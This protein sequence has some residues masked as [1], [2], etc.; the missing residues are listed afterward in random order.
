MNSF[1]IL[2][3]YPR[4]T[5]SE[6]PWG[7]QNNFD[8]PP[9]PFLIRFRPLSNRG[10]VSENPWGEQKFLGPPLPPS[11][12]SHR[13]SATLK[14]IFK[15]FRYFWIFSCFLVI[16][17]PFF[18]F[19]GGARGPS[20]PWGRGGQDGLGGLTPS[21][22]PIGA[23]AFKSILLVIRLKNLAFWQFLVIFPFL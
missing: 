13:I 4:R 19:L 9:Q 7:G 17:Y 15:I 10:A 8:P 20:V 3:T 14:S 21:T 22:G 23:H 16:F 11:P 6:N 5:A 12:F 2:N 1:Q 18:P